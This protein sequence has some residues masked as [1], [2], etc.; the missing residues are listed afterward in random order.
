MSLQHEKERIDYHTG[1]VE[2]VNA[3]FVQVYIDKLDL[4]IEMTSENPTAV[5]LF[6]WLLK[7]MDKKNALVVSQN[8]LAESLSVTRQTIYTSITY[9]KQKKAIAVFKSGGTNIYAVNAQI[10]W[11]SNAS[12]KR[13]AMFDA[14]VYIAESEQDDEKPLFKTDLIGHATKKKNKVKI[15]SKGSV[16]NFEKL[17]NI[18][19][20]DGSSAGTQLEKG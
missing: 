4:I 14:K 3:N 20:T 2:E 13:Y 12:G 15:S 11:K 5:K 19:E 6:T 1:E 16:D 9:L 8:A 17:K 7:H 18:N 10:A